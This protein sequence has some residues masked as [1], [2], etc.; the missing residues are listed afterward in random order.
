MAMRGGQRWTECIGSA[1]TE[2]S[3]PWTDGRC[4]AASV[5]KAGGTWQLPCA[6]LVRKVCATC[7]FSNRDAEGGLEGFR[8]SWGPK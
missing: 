4:C 7:C 8:S 6:I 1:A 3:H 2:T 5:L